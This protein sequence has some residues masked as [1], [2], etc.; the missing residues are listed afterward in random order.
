MVELP[1]TLAGLN[2]VFLL[3]TELK[4]LALFALLQL[5]KKFPGVKFLA[6]GN[7]LRSLSKLLLPELSSTSQKSSSLSLS[8]SSNTILALGR[9]LPCYLVVVI[10]TSF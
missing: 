3:F 6:E 10:V 7:F 1:P 4:K 8:S 2:T 9:I 5:L